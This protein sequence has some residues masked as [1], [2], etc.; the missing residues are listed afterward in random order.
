M[1]YGKRSLSTQFS[2]VILDKLSNCSIDYRLSISLIC[3]SVKN[4]LINL[5]LLYF[6]LEN[7]QMHV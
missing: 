5:G 2:I 7:K 3:I 6:N 1:F 4:D